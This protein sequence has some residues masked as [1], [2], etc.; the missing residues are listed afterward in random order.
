[1]KIRFFGTSH[2]VPSAERFCSCTCLEIGNRLYL[3]DCGAPAIDLM[4]RCGL[5]PDQL[6][7]VFFTH[8]H[9]DHTDGLLNLADLCNWY[10]K[11]SSFDI[12]MTEASGIDAY[13]RTINVVEADIPID[14]SRIRFKFM[15][16]DFVYDDGMLRVTPFPTAHMKYVGD[17]HPSYSYLIEAEGKKIVFT[18]DLSHHM[19]DRDFPEIALKEN[20]DLTVCEMAHFS[21]EEAEYFLTGYKGKKLLFNHV[22][23]VEKLDKIKALDGK[24]GYPIDILSDG[25]IIE[26]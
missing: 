15:D 23:P 22:F 24:Y 26:L 3:I 18:G 17:G 10:F 4:L 8:I 16:K 5:H 11:E 13:K 6:R 12:Y 21:P 19:R 14:E 1:M 25:D 7:A 9:G 20:V 2:G